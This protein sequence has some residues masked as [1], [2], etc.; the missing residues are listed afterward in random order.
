M[1]VKKE[2]NPNIE[3]KLIENI[4]ALQ[5]IETNLAEKFNSLSSQ[6]SQLLKLFETSAKTFSQTLANPQ[7][8]KDRELIEKLDE[9]IEQNRKITSTLSSIEENTTKT[10]ESF[11]KPLIEEKEEMEESLSS[12]SEDESK[13]ENAEEKT[14]ESE[15][16]Y[17]Y[18]KF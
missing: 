10:N 18:P 3:K 1:P 2:A 16:Q 6:I 13:E 12:S 15:S 5:K 9:L 11:Q 17:T 14:E 7:S 4:V 8:G